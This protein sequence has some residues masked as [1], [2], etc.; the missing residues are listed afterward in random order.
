MHAIRSILSVLLLTIA[1]AAPAQT[2]SSL[3]RTTDEAAIRAV[4]GRWYLEHRAGAKG[5][6]FSLLAPGSIDAS[7]GHVFPRRPS[8]MRSAAASPPVYTSL[9][10]TALTFRH[11]ISRLDL[12][13]RFAR[14][15]VWERGYF[16]AWA[17]QRTY[18][19][20]GAAT[21]VLEKQQDGR[22]LVLAHRTG[23]MGIPPTMA[24]TP[25][26]DLRELFYSTVGRNRD[27]EQD[28]RNVPRF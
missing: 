25:M 7:P 2:G 28:A 23:T 19:R 16:Y 9:A 3:A 8:G 10:A 21:F 5:R 26:P 1:A 17:V 13:T 14:V 20:L 22:W 24:T 4:I 18:E 27:R 11:E 15:G 12:D 6:V